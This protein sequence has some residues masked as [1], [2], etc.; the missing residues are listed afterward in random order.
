MM[1]FFRFPH[2]P[3]IAWLGNGLP[4]DDK[5]L[6]PQETDDLLIADVVVEEKLDGANLGISIGADSQ[7][8]VQNRGQYLVEPFTGQF[9]RLSSWLAQHRYEFNHALDKQLILFGEW[10][11]AKHSLDYETLPDWFLLFDVYDREQR[12]F[13][14]TTRRNT[15]AGFLGLNVVPQLLRD[16]VTWSQLKNLLAAS[17]S[18]FRQGPLEGLVIRRESTEWCEARA[19]L[20]RAEFT[21]TINEHWRRRA[22]QWN[23]LQPP[24]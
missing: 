11:A 5:L 24:G 4:R 8:R 3:H 9:S 20:V 7:L 10:C 18:Q 21:Q 22:I 1:D 19:K 23:R 13:W 2:T 15:L 14:S 17:S 16:H 12:R 6:T